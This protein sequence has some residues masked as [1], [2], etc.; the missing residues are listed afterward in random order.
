ME[1]TPES[2]MI[3]LIRNPGDVV[4]SR[5]DAFRQG[6]WAGRDRDYCTANKLAKDTER[7][8]KELCKVS[9]EVQEA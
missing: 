4:A 2:R 7:L 6:G 1:V 9:L 5:L 8:A 3:C